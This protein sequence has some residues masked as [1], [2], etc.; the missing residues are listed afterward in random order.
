[1]PSTKRD[2]RDQIGILPQQR[3]QPRRAVQIGEEMIEQHQ[4]GVRIVGARQLL[5]QDRQQRLE[6]AARHLASQ[7]AMAA[8]KPMPDDGRGFQR[9][10]EA[11]L[12]QPVQRLVVVGVGR[13]RQRRLVGAGRLFEQARIVALHLVEMVEQHL[14]EGVA[15]GK[16]EKARE[17]LE[18]GA[19]G[20]QRLRLLVVDHLQPV[21]DRAQEAIGRF[22]V[23]ARGLRRSSGPSL[24]LVERGERVAVAQVADCARRRSIAGSARK[25]RSR[26]CR[27]GRA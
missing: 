5:E 3:Q 21:L 15:I 10:A 24:E 26:E 22:H 19:L 1:M 14:G 8:G 16:A 6:M 12:G 7:R 11:E 25:T 2:Q 9:R 13:K 18:L 17:A 23:V 27:R 20:R 4:R